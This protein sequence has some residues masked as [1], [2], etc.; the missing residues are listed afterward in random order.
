[1]VAEGAEDA[2]T[3][4]ALRHAGC[5]LVQGYFLSR[6]LPAEQLDAWLAARDTVAAVQTS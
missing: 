2:E 4:A 5:D 1:M 3:W 6:P